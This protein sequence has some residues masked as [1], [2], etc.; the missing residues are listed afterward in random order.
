VIDF[1][2]IVLAIIVVAVIVG[3]RRMTA[4]RTRSGHGEVLAALAPV[5]GGSVSGE[6][7][8]TGRYR[9]YDVEVVLRTADPAAPGM[10]GNSATNLVEAVQL[11]LLGAPGAQPWAVW[12]EPSLTGRTWDWHFARADGGDFLPFLGRLSRLA[13]LP[14]AD[15]DLPDRLRAAGIL[16]AFERV[17]PPTKDY[18]PRINFVP[19]LRMAMMERLRVTRDLPAAAQQPPASAGPRLELEVER[20]SDDDPTPERFRALLDTALEIAEINARANPATTTA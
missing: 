19:D 15:P 4:D 16:D 1:L 20:M 6:Q 7:V 13:G 3:S 2:V 10:T 8:L 14:P 17:S 5:V 11:R 12:R 9:G 18:L